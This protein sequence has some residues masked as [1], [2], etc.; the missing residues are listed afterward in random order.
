MCGFAGFCNS[1]SCHSENELKNIVA[2]MVDTLKH[3]GPDD[4]GQYTD[5]EKGIAIGHR[6]LSVIDVSPTGRQPMQSDDG[7]YLLVYNGEVYNYNEIRKQLKMLDHRFVGTSDTEVVLKAFCEWGV[8]DSL[9]KFIGMFALALWDTQGKALYLARDRMGEKPLFYGWCGKTFLF[10]SELKALVAYPDWSND[11]DRNVL[12]LFLRHNYI[13]AP[14]SIYRNIFKLMPGTFLRLSREDIVQ[15]SLPHPRPYWSLSDTVNKGNSERFSGSDSEAIQCLDKLL[16]QAVSGQMLADVPLGA[17]LSGGIDSS[18]IVA[19]MQTQSSKP[20]KTFTIGFKD[21]AYNE[22]KYAKQVAN[23]LGTDHTE[24][25]ITPQDAIDVIPLLPRL[26]DEPFADSSQIPT[27]LISKL[28]RQHVT[29]SLSGDGADEVFCGYNRHVQLHAVWNKTKRFPQWFKDILAFGLCRFPTSWSETILRRKKWG[30]LSDQIQKLAKIIVMNDPEEMYY[31]LNSF[32]DSPEELV[33]NSCEPR[34]IFSNNGIWPNLGY[35]ERLLYVESMLSLPDDMLVKLDR[36][37]MG[38]S[39]ET[40]T[41]FLDHRVVEFSWSLPLSMKIRNG[42]GKWIL[43]QILYQYVP[44]NLIERPKAGFGIP[45]DVWLKGPLRDWSEFLLDESKLR[46]QGYLNP[47]LVRE[48]WTEHLAGK[49][50]WQYHLWDV[51]MFQAWHEHWMS[52]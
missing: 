14:Y 41:P 28:A 47:S 13:P 39:L 1:K 17:F 7:R 10:G 18:C 38:V 9:Q 23:Y 3:R 31:Q 43:R 12:T 8:E 27:Y 22:A 42:I 49:R 25:Y 11:I 4:T 30:I 26:Y 2:G 51:L 21:I 36:A 24:L 15:V 35:L 33:L 16:R 20:I 19:L 50:K 46:H 34:T 6:R 44:P 5:A 32:W 29:V 45:I 48:K 40:R 52:A 37:A